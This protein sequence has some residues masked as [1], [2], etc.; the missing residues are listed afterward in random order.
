MAGLAIAIG[1]PILL[2][3]VYGIVPVSLCRAGC[4][5]SSSEG[6]KFDL[7]DEENPVHMQSDG[8]SVSAIS[9]IGAASIGDVS[10]SV[11]SGSQVGM[12]NNNALCNLQHFCQESTVAL[13]GSVNGKKFDFQPDE[14]S[15]ESFS[16]I[17][18]NSEKSAINDNFSTKGLAGSLASCKQVSKRLNMALFIRTRKYSF[19]ETLKLGQYVFNKTSFFLINN[20]VLF[21]WHSLMSVNLV[22]VELCLL[23]LKSWDFQMEHMA[24]FCHPQMNESDYTLGGKCIDK[25]KKT[26]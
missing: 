19:V 9:R 17:T 10:I 6:F 22:L 5:S 8:L 14:M 7:D 2:F 15:T 16:A 25:D 21:I 12:Q 13:A 4:A 11:T 23:L 1:V 20:R 18:A 26:G 24:Y 3:Y